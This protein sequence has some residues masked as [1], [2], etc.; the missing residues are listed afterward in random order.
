MPDQKSR[1]TL[2]G[3]ITCSFSWFLKPPRSLKW[4]SGFQLLQ[5]WWL[6]LS[7]LQCHRRCRWFYRFPQL[8]VR[9][10]QWA[11][12]TWY[13]LHEIRGCMMQHP[14]TVCLRDLCRQ[15][16]SNLSHKPLQW[17]VS[18]LHS[19]LWHWTPPN[20]I[21]ALRRQVCVS[22]GLQTG[23]LQIQCGL[24]VRSFQIEG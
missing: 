18:L 24:W 10:R 2:L 6:D 20:S 11:S 7:C 17:L 5:A 9:Y 4:L 16:H 13:L 14:L 15:A 22:Q 1:Q 23:W 21:H 12:K 3:L 8:C 19:N